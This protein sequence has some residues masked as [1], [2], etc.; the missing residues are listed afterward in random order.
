MGSTGASPCCHRSLQSHPT[1]TC[2]AAIR[3]NCALSFMSTSGRESAS[4]S[5]LLLAATT[6]AA[7]S[8][9]EATLVMGL[10]CRVQGEEFEV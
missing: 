5:M 4:A 9:T 2:S 6:E 8:C 3:A 1:R 7:I 10:G